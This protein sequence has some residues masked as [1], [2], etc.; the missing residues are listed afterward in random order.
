MKA[1]NKIRSAS[2]ERLIAIVK[3]VTG[4]D[5]RE[6]TRKA[7]FVHARMIYYVI[8][9]EIEKHSLAA[10]GSAF[11]KD[12]AT[13]L[14]AIRTFKNVRHQIGYLDYFYKKCLEIYTNHTDYQAMVEEEDIRL[15]ILERE[16]EIE[17]LNSYIADLK[18]EISRLK[19]KQ[20][21]EYAVVFNVIRTRLPKG[22]IETG[23]KKITAVLNG[24]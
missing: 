4:N 11:D 16:G 6:N 18:N 22:K 12:H 1:K 23:I 17:G 8:I 13:A 10:A 3:A 14:N 24:I 5:P 21:D 20:N 19:E 7:E 9:T 2:S 15:R